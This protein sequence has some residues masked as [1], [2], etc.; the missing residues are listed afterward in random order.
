MGPCEFLSGLSPTLPT[1]PEDDFVNGI[2][3]LLRYRSMGG[4]AGSH[5]L[6]PED[7]SVSKKYQ[8]ICA[9]LN[10]LF[11]FIWTTW[12]NQICYQMSWLKGPAQNLCVEANFKYT[13][14]DM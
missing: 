7:L 2:A 8:K 12:K 5:C 6:Q 14:I 13:W 9:F 10:R 11:I 4:H 3:P 1:W